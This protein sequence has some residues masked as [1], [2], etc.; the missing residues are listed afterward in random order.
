MDSYSIV[1]NIGR[2][3]YSN[4][5][6]INGLCHQTC[7]NFSLGAKEKAKKYFSR[8]YKFRQMD[9]EYASW[10]MVS[11]FVSPQRL[12]RNFSYH[13]STRNQWARDDPAFMILLIPWIFISTS[14]YSAHLGHS[15]FGWLKLLFW[16]IVFECIF[17]GLIVASF[18]WIISNRWMIR[19]EHSG[20]SSTSTTIF[21][22]P[23]RAT[24]NYTRRSSMASDDESLN[25]DGSYSHPPIVEWAYAFDIHLNAF[26]SCFII[27]RNIQPVFFYFIRGKTIASILL[28][29]TFWLVGILY[30]VYITFLGY[31]ALPFLRRTRAI[32]LTG[33]VIVVLY[34]VS[35]VL[36]WNLTMGMCSFYSLF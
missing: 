18:M 7:T 3:Q 26:F 28:G 29:N 24:N 9:F 23:S 14:V 35:L 4:G 25:S 21:G 2:K 16:S 6:R 1:D 19:R 32:L 33:T 10:Q 11:I 27:L 15:F 8:F 5:K 36:R 20:G 12:Y 17:S 22:S 30:Y 31:K 13:H 34:V